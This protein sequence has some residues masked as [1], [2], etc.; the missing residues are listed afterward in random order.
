MSKVERILRL[1]GEKK[2]RLRAVKALTSLQESLLS[3]ALDGGGTSKV[4]DDI[5]DVYIY[6]EQLKIIYDFTDSEINWHVKYRLE[7]TLDDLRR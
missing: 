4:L 3:N 7:K 1:C 5:V 6:L 2:Q